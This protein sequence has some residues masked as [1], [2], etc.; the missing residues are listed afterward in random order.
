MTFEIQMY[1][2]DLAKCWGERGKKDLPKPNRLRF[3][4]FLEALSIDASWTNNL[5][6]N[7]TIGLIKW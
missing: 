3:L 7:L 4:D 1:A 6:I 2:G 5:I